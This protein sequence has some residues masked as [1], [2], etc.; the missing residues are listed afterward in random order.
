MTASLGLTSSEAAV[1]EGCV[2]GLG[3]QASATADM[4]SVWRIVVDGAVNKGLGDVI[5]RTEPAVSKELP[6]EARTA[7]KVL[8]HGMYLA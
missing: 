5:D 3:I 7:L 2:Y 8:S 4:E 6:E 1:H